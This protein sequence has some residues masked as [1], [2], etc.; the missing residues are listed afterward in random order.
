[1][2]EFI[3]SGILDDAP[4]LVV[5]GN[6]DPLVPLRW[7][8]L[9]WEALRRADLEASPKVLRGADH[10]GPQLFSSEALERLASSKETS[11]QGAHQD[12]DFPKGTPRP[13]PA[14]A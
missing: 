14:A 6:R 12:V 8:Q 13:R 5:D 9:L 4:W 7:S 2:A 1:M 3:T 10:A 11:G